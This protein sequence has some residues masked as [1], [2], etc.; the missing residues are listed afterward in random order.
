MRHLRTR[1]RQSTIILHDSFIKGFTFKAF[2]SLM[3]HIHTKLSIILLETSGLV[4]NNM[5]VWVT[6]NATIFFWPYHNL[7]TGFKISCK[8]IPGNIHSSNNSHT[9]VMVCFQ[10]IFSFLISLYSFNKKD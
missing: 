2:F 8:I 5:V 7:Q 4:P 1:F 3:I 6:R 10:F 9:L